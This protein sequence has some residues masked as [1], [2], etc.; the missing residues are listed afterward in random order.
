MSID[1]ITILALFMIA[2][3]LPSMIASM[4][5]SLAKIDISSW[6][7]EEDKE[8]FILYPLYPVFLNYW[9]SAGKLNVITW[10]VFF[11]PFF[12]ET[13]FFAIPSMYGF[14]YALVS[15]IA[16]T[17]VHIGRLISWMMKSGYSTGQIIAGT[18]AGLIVY[19]PHA[20]LSAY[21]WSKGLGLVSVFYHSFHNLLAYTGTVRERKVKIKIGKYYRVR[22]RKY[23][24]IREWE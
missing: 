21:L 12:E 13:F 20:V 11:F 4:I 16:W 18:F 23:Y 7:N 9:S 19:V 8:V 17:M 10:T 6:S 5:F 14:I 3:I 1:P 15:G 2:D 22:Q 24:K